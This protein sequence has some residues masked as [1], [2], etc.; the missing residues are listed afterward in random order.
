MSEN[1][2]VELEVDSLATREVRAL[3]SQCKFDDWKTGPIAKLRRKIVD[4]AKT[5]PEILDGQQA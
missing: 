5:N 1:R 3:A 4:L 2:D